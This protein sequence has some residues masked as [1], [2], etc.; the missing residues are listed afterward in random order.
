MWSLNFY[1]GKAQPPPSVVLLSILEYLS[2]ENKLQLFAPGA[3]LSPASF[4][5]RNKN[6]IS[7]WQN[8]SSVGK[9]TRKTKLLS[10]SDLMSMESKPGTE[11]ENPNAYCIH[12]PRRLS[13]GNAEVEV[14]FVLSFSRLCA[15]LRLC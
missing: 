14:T 11:P 10:E 1:L 2:T 4:S 9:S 5:I 8:L 6:Q 7:S 3:H 13:A 15:F 12:L